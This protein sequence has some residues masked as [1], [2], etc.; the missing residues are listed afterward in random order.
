MKSSTKEN[1]W[2]ALGVLFFAN[3]LVGWVFMVYSAIHFVIKYW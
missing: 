3:V 2:V 1:W